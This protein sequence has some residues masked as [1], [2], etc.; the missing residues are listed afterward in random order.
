VA[1]SE[2]CEARPLPPDVMPA[3]IPLW[4]LW[5]EG[6]WVRDPGPDRGPLWY[7]REYLA[8]LAATE[9]NGQP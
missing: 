1:V 9:R 5:H 2:L 8:V 3:P 7:V 4:G 6:D